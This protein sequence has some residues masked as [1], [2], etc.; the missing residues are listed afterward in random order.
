MPIKL[1]WIDHNVTA[2][3]RKVYRSTSKIDVGN[4]GVPLATLPGD[5]LTY[6]DN[7]VQRGVTYYYVITSIQ[8]DDE[9]PSAQYVIAYIPYTGPGP[10]ALIRGTWE[11]G[12]FGRVPIDDILGHAELVT[13]C[14]MAGLATVNALTGNYWHKVVYKG[15][16]LFFP[17]LMVASTLSFQSLYQKGLVY[18]LEPSANWPA[19]IKTLLGT[20]TQG[21]VIS[22]GQHRFVVRLPT[23]R[24]TL[25]TTG[26]T[27]ASLRG[28]EIDKVFASLYLN[29][30]PLADS[31]LPV[32]DDSFSTIGVATHR[33]TA[34]YHST[35]GQVNIVTRTCKDGTSGNIDTVQATVLAYNNAAAAVQWTPVLELQA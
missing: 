1:D 33:L 34:D 8:G 6:T 18:G 13:A 31:G 28:G 16:I 7:T 15:K 23:S 29:R 2:E 25:S 24:E 26:T 11:L 5:A 21:K 3:S 19:P 17:N 27:A 10:Q 20:V 9:A 14:D 4:L 22:S 12:Y 30:D 35:A 32:M